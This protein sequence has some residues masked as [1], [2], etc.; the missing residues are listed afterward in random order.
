MYFTHKLH[1]LLVRLCDEYYKKDRGRTDTVD[2]ISS[3]CMEALLSVLSAYDV[4]L[5][6]EENLVKE[7]S[8]TWYK[9]L[10]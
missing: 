4:Y 10:I 7:S 3:T 5:Y 9:E 1:V 8:P 6:T 2:T